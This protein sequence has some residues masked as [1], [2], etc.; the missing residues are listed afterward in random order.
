MERGF[1]MFL[2]RKTEHCT[3]DDTPLS[4]DDKPS[5][6]RALLSFSMLGMTM[7]PLFM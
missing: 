2:R 4:T 3:D 5:L 1:H 6:I 7:F